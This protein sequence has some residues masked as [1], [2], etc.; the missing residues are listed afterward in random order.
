MCDQPPTGW[1]ADLAVA[2]SG[3][4]VALSWQEQDCAGFEL[5]DRGPAGDRQL[6]GAGGRVASNWA[7]GPVFSPDG[8]FVLMTEGP[9][10]CWWTESPGD[11]EAEAPGGVM[12]AGEVVVF[13]L[14]GGPEHRLAVEVEVEA[15]WSATDPDSGESA[16]LGEPQFLNEAEF[17]LRL[18][19]GEVRTMGLPS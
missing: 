16:L 13:D 6:V 7:T 18:P 5:V 10:P 1:F 14:S 9:G 17:T 19:T 8:R 2:P 4:L 3:H 11:C 15:G 12:Q